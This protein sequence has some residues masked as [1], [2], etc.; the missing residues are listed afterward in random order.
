MFVRAFLEVIMPFDVH[1]QLVDDESKV[2]KDAVERH[3]RDL[4]KNLTAL[5][6]AHHP[7]LGANRWP[8]RGV[9][10]STNGGQTWI[11]INNGLRNRAVLTLSISADGRHLYAA[12]DG[13]R[14]IA[15]R[16]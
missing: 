6:D 4:I 14:S 8:G 12:T 13:E 2:E 11:R 1:D 16:S 3:W 5:L 9:Y 15:M 7:I 10:R